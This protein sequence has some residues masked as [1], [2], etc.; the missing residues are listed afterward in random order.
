[1]SPQLVKDAFARLEVL[2]LGREVHVA[3]HIPELPA[4]GV[5]AQDDVNDVIVVG[6]DPLT[7]LQ[8]LALVDCH[9]DVMPVPGDDSAERSL[10]LL[11]VASQKRAWVTR[12]S[13]R[14]DGVA[15]NLLLPRLR[16]PVWA[17]GRSTLLLVVHRITSL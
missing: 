6:L 10:L 16:L 15:T 1:M 3:E 17:H 5:V 11:G 14:G 13:P 7:V 8:G 4:S 12:D 9:L 2:G